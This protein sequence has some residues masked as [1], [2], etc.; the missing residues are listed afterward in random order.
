MPHDYRYI[1]RYTIDPTFHPAQRIEELARF[2][3]ASRI[4]EVMYLFTAEELNCGHPT[5]AQYGP[6]LHLA[7]RLKQRLAEDGIALSLNP[8]TTTHHMA[9]GRRLQP[10]QDFEL[11]V[12]ANGV[13]SP[14]SA[15]PLCPDWQQYLCDTF[16]TWARDL[17]PVAIWIEDDWRLHNHGQEL[18][19]GGCFCPRHLA[20]FAAHVGEPRVDRETLLAAVLAPGPP[21]PWRGAW[22]DVCRD[23]LLEPAIRLEQA[24]HAAAPHV[25]IGL[26]SSNPDVHSMEGRDWA[27]MQ[28]AWGCAPAFLTRPHLPPYTETNAIHDV[29]A[30]TRH[31]LASLARPIDVFPELENSPRCG[32][33]SKSAAFSVWE[34]LHSVC[35]GSAGITINHYDMMGCGI[36]LDPGL[37]TALRDARDRLSAVARLGIDDQR[38][39]GIRVLFHP[40]I[41]RHRVCRAPS[42]TPLE[43]SFNPVPT[44]H[45]TTSPSAGLAQLKESS[46]HWSRT[47]YTL[48]IAHRFACAND[49]QAAPVAVNGQTL[50]AFADEEIEQLLAGPMLLDAEAADV[51]VERG[52]AADIGIAGGTWLGLE[53]AAYAYESIR[54]G[55][56]GLHGLAH[57]RMCAQRCAVRIFAMRPVAG[58][59]VRTD[60]RQAG[61]AVVAPG[62][63]VFH[64]ARGGRIASLAYP[65]GG[66]A[67]FVSFFNVFRMKLMQDL[68]F[69]LAPDAPLATVAPGPLH[70]YR[71]PT[72]EGLLLAVLNPTHDAV[73][74]CT[75]RLG[76]MPSAPRQTRVLT[77][78]GRWEAV[79]LPSEAS[80]SGRCLTV[81]APIA[82][83]DAVFVHC[84]A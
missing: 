20:R 36:A 65:V 19:Y 3:A 54:A 12:G 48:G 80:G 31:T 32:R 45:P 55:D 21:H 29:P 72:A 26:M 51:L 71:A 68:L 59:S 69:E 11:M 46:D 14:I 62:L 49:D 47:F 2:C 82:P 9:R 5:A 23:T 63:I 40:E 38:A 7:R 43:P 22:L 24:I 44:A 78:D 53:E 52:H 27:A 15:C 8:W 35:Y 74:R 61:H 60:I 41:A 73:D 37:G 33:F 18:G 6:W 34:C 70:V 1:L 58:A 64:N 10:G 84:V 25:R 56:P 28:R 75:I 81:T 83:L 66:A 39:H 79:A 42:A 4:E 13:V 50:R 16:A 30:V 67:F 57:P 76:A 17:E 77:A